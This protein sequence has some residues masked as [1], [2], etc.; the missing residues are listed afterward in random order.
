[1]CVFLT[2][3]SKAFSDQAWSFVHLEFYCM[4]TWCMIEGRL[5]TGSDCS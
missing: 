4:R 5:I 2:G 1:M 3:I